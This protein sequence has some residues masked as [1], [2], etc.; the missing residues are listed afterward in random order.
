LIWNCSDFDVLRF[1]NAAMILSVH[2][3]FMREALLLARQAAA[4]G[5]VPVGALVV[6]DGVIVGRGF[7]QPIFSHDPTAHAE[8]VALRDAAISLSNYRLPGCV[9]YVTIEPCTMCFG[10]AVHARIEQI[11]YGATEPKSGCIESNLQLVQQD[12]FNHQVAV[13][14]GVLGDESRALISEFFAARR[15]QKKSDKV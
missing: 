5:E 11:I 8:I 1:G 9:L 6:R 14:G 15:L 13:R 2:E 4:V 12:C 7:N 10:A 3:T